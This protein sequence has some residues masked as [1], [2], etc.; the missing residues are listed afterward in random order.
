LIYSNSANIQVE[1]N[2]F[3]IIG[4]NEINSY[5]IIT[6]NINCSIINPIGNI[7]NIG[8]FNN[9]DEIFIGTSANI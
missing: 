9:A 2:K 3:K 6:D 4:N 7:L 8:N 5:L 1:T